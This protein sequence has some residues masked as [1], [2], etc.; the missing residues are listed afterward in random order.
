MWHN[1][2]GSNGRFAHSGA[3]GQS[4]GKVIMKVLFV[5]VEVA[6]YAKVGG[7]AD[8]AGSL[9]Q[10]LA[11]LGHEVVVAMPAYPM[12]RGQLPEEAAIPL[13]FSL[14][15]N[16][17]ENAALILTVPE[18][19][20]RHWLIECAGFEEC[21]DSQ[22]LY[23]PGRDAYLRFSAALM[24]ACETFG[25][26]PDV[27]HCNDWHTAFVPVFVREKGGDVWR[28]AACVFT[29]HNLAYQGVF[30]RDTLQAAGLPDRLF[31][32]DKLETFG[33]CNFLKAGCVYADQVTTVSPTYAC[34]IQTEQYGCG[35]WG[36]MRHLEE[37]RRLHGILNG[38]DL[39]RFD[40]ATDPAIPSNYSI[41][42]LDG[43]SECRGSLRDECG[44][45]A[46]EN[47]MLLGSVSRL[48][49]QKGFDLLLDAMPQLLELPVQIVIQALGD[50]RLAE[51]LR[52]VQASHPRQFRYVETFDPD[53]AQRIY[54]GCDGFLMPSHFE[55]CGLGQMIALRYGTVPIARR[56]GGLAD[57]VFEG[58]NGFVFEEE[59]GDALYG[60]VHRA[61]STFI[62]PEVW[63]ALVQRC[64]GYDFSWGRSA[65][66][67]ERVYDLALRQ[68]RESP[69]LG[70]LKL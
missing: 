13:E 57:T 16:R 6:P 3:Q 5:A 35:L 58:E 32:W 63:K 48:S 56:T 45:A 2:L 52:A 24:A 60:A 59:S 33:K 67:Y 34:E 28:D 62:E 7:L 8:V 43:K 30:D 11:A 69:S 31:T 18:R 10:A 49:E 55:P 21:R 70:A 37:Y 12:V 66:E 51:Q 26:V 65:R 42:D 53:L 41:E 9:P 19:G 50:P 61:W 22:T 68:R 23:R 20:V 1:F 29:I 44:L 47:A 17:P 54:A 64:M 14:Q 15:S 46:D 38:I 39:K 4:P 36:L 25:P 40:P 27:V